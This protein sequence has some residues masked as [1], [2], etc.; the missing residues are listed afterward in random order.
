M[1]DQ[2]MTKSRSVWLKEKEAESV[3]FFVL[4]VKI[5]FKPGSRESIKCLKLLNNKAQE[6]SPVFS[7]QAVRKML[8][9]KFNQVE[10]V[11]YFLFI[12]YVAY[13]ISLTF[14]TP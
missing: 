2:L 14:I 12:A 3:D 8:L 4:L 1:K 11:G 6:M 7:S 10:H 9:K 5:N 13:L